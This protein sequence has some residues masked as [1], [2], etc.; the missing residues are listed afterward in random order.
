MLPTHL[1]SAPPA[2]PSIQLQGSTK[3]YDGPATRDDQP[4]WFANLKADRE[5]VLSGIKFT[6]GVFDTPQ[7]K[8]TQTSWIQPQMHPCARDSSQPRF[9]D[10]EILTV[11]VAL[12]GMIA[13]SSI[14]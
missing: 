14:R 2:P 10:Q 7:L 8:W 3:Q 12:P 5:K 1:A 11:R 6:G 4:A 13:S 9:A